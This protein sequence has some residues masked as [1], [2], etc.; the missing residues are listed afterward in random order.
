MRTVTEIDREISVLEEKLEHVEGR[1]TE[2]YTRIVGYY[3]SLRNWNSG[4]REEYA[5][6]ILFDIESAPAELPAVAE[7]AVSATEGPQLERYIYF[8]R[9][10]CPNCPPVRT[11][12]A[13]LEIPGGE[14]DVDTDEG[15]RAALEYGI[16]TTPTVIFFN[17]AGDEVCRASSTGEL[18]GL[19]IPQMA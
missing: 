19:K 8:F 10:T 1:S 16:Y 17:S 9:E 11:L 2:V 14:M 3:R 7:A 15:T 4:K 13:E 5:D 18:S 12:L 6:R